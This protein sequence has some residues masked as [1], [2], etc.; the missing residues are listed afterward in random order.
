MLPK[1][2]LAVSMLAKLKVYA[3]GQHPHQAQQPEPIELAVK[4]SRKKVIEA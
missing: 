4:K 2:K 3:G 1:N